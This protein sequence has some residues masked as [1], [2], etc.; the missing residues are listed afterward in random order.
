M[1]GY[2]STFAIDIDH[3]DTTDRDHVVAN[4]LGEAMTWLR[5]TKGDQD[6]ETV[7]PG[8]QTTLESGREVVY[9]HD[10]T[11]SGTEYGRL[12]AFDPPQGDGQ[13]W[14]TNLLVGLDHNASGRDRKS[15]PEVTI[16]IIAPDDPADPGRP[17]WTSRPRLVQAILG[18]FTCDDHGFLMAD[19]PRPIEE[20]Q[21]EEL[22]EQLAETDHHGL[23]ILC[24][25]DGT[26]PRSIWQDRLALITRE[27]LGQAS[28]FL[29]DRAAMEV[30]N[31]QVSP[32]HQLAAYSPRTFRPGALLDD[33]SDGY[34][35]RALSME[36]LLNS[37]IDQLTRS[38]GRA[39]REHANRI[40]L[41]RSLRRLDVI[42]GM[43]L[44]ALYR[45][46]STG[47]PVPP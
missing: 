41:D 4:V 30:F 22:L 32:G 23:V 35:H 12:V 9:L 7:E 16:E 27:T 44:D 39:S 38:F 47:A 5:R 46:S 43:R 3:C 26:V 17:R 20:D 40:A 15:W 24:G 25:E 18:S 31:T 34:R 45:A 14:V 13:R 8:V 33:V 10:R 28:V 1:L 2:R 29:L 42:T 37:R 11:E 21:V 36:T 19:G 6:I